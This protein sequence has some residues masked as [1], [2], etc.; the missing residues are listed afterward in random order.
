MIFDTTLQYCI[1]SSIKSDLIPKKKKN[2]IKLKTT[3]ENFK[4]NCIFVMKNKT[5]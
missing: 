1:Y 5:E 4:K 2:Y 3:K